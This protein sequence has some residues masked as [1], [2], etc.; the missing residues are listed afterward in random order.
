MAGML[1]DN[2]KK[3]SFG[4]VRSFMEAAGRPSNS[5]QST[6]DVSVVSK[7]GESLYQEIGL[8]ISYRYDHM[9]Y[10]VALMWEEDGS[11]PDYHSIGLHGE[12]STNFQEF[13]FSNGV[14]S[15]WDGDKRISIFEA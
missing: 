4:S 1:N 11:Q 3:K 13:S 6:V 2:E 10:K 8:F 9:D 12:Y 14:L 15:F 7:R 5:F